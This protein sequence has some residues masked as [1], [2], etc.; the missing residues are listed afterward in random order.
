LEIG[1][2]FSREDDDHGRL[3][4]AFARS[5]DSTRSN[6]F[7]AGVTRPASAPARPRVME[8]SSAAKPGFALLINRTPS[9]ST[10]L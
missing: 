5:I 7:A 8:A 3:A 6:A 4:F 9:R 2:R 10:S 1:F